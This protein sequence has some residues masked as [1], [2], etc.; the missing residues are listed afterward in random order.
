MQFRDCA[1]S[2][3]GRIHVAG[4]SEAK[5][6]TSSIIRVPGKDATYL[7]SPTGL[8]SWRENISATLKMFQ[9]KKKRLTASASS[10]SSMSKATLRAN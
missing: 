10:E 8:A 3:N 4:V 6:R 7:V 2:L 5:R 1:E 9:K